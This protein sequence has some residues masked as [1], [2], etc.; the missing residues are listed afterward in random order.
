M[1]VAIIGKGTSS[2]VQACTLLKHGHKITIYY[3][4]NIPTLSVGES[5]TPHVDVLL[6]N[7][8]GLTFSYLKYH[9]I[10]SLK[11]GVKFINW[12]KGKTFVHD[13]SGF[14]NYPNTN[15]AYHLDT[16]S[17]NDIAHPVLEEH[18]VKYIPEKVVSIEE[19]ENA[20][21]INGKKYDF[22]VNCSG[23]SDEKSDYQ[24]PLFST[25]NS[26][27]LRPKNNTDHEIDYT[28]HRATEDGWQF[29]LP[30]PDK[31]I[32]RTGYLFNSKYITQEKIV[33][34][35]GDGGRFVSWT[36]KQCKFLLKNKRHAYNGNRLC[37]FEPLHAYS[38][39]LYIL[40]SELLCE[41]LETDMT[42]ETI[43]NYNLH[44]RKVMIEYQMEVAFHYQYGSI[45]K[46]IFWQ[47][48]QNAAEN[49]TKTHHSA[50]KD[51]LQSILDS[52]YPET[53]PFLKNSLIN[54]NGDHATR[55]FGHTFYE[56]MYVHQQMTNE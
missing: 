11:R 3:D 50:H 6:S 36:P 32:V 13:L 18:G 28:I 8:I 40:F 49:I 45:F 23:W 52:G 51:Y 34:K 5:T 26:A 19:T 30:F 31:G 9:K 37:F 43:F 17:F 12:G 33:E 39:I 25:V 54:Y 47:E 55:V 46:S 53:K 2:I 44:Y 21:E 15:F 7:T 1:N 27:F 41:Y 48:V 56:L 24:S 10:V 16:R 20:I 22:L 42:K 35:L 38:F 14:G 29:E 4:P